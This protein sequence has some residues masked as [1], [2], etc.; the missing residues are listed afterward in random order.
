MRN[1]ID[2]SK[3]W[4]VLCVSAVSTL[5]AGCGDSDVPIGEQQNPVANGGSAG[6]DGHCVNNA[7]CVVGSHFD[8]AACACVPD[9]ADAG[10]CVDNQAC[11]RGKHWDKTACACVADAADA[12]CTIKAQCVVGK[13]FDSAACACVPDAVGG[14]CID[15]VLCTTQSH[16]DSNRCACVPNDCVSEE[17]GVC[18][19]N[20]VT[21]CSCASGLICKAQ[22]SNLPF[23]DVGGTCQRAAK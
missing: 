13:H 11:V 4:A 7:F 8:S 20:M 16:W 23:G 19:G 15:N 22:N 12:G 5:G 10:R 9:G 18:G 17:G 2:V 6:A 1:L 14:P 21:A 3:L